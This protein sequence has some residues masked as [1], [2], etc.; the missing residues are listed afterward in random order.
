MLYIYKC[1]VNVASNKYR[2]YLICFEFEDV[3]QTVILR[4]ATLD[5][6]NL[7]NR[8]LCITCKDKINYFSD[9]IKSYFMC[10]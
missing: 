7:L 8:R 6:I 10:F 9:K 3:F 1:L 2:N 4:L 5:E